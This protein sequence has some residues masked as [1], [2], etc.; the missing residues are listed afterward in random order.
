MD[1]PALPMTKSWTNALDI[2]LDVAATFTIKRAKTIA[3]QNALPGG[4]NVKNVKFSTTPDQ[5]NA[6][7]AKLNHTTSHN[8]LLPSNNHQSSVQEIP[9]ILSSSLPKHKNTQ[10]VEMNIFPGSGPNICLAGPQHIAQLNFDVT[11]HVTNRFLL[12]EV[13]NSTVPYDCPSPFK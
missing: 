11:D 5:A 1:P 8:H 7:I 13:L 2:V 10:S 3:Q 4:N 9:A 6:L 12:L